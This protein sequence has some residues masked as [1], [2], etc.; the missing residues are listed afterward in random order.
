MTSLQFEGHSQLVSLS[1]QALHVSSAKD[2][3][4]LI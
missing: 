3:P 4:K 2:F 1:V